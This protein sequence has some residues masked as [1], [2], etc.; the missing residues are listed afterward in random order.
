MSCV[1]QALNV[2]RRNEIFTFLSDATKLV[3]NFKLNKG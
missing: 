2:F 3:N 1:K